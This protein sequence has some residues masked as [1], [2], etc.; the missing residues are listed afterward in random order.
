MNKKDLIN[1]INENNISLGDKAHTEVKYINS[2]KEY[3]RVATKDIASAAFFITQ[4]EYMTGQ[5]IKV[6]GGRS[7]S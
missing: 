5:V 7:L 3:G 1:F 6:D 2:T 4:S